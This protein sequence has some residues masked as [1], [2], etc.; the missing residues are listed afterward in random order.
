MMQH[1]AKR[2]PIF[3][4]LLFGLAFVLFRFTG[5]RPGS[6]AYHLKHLGKL[7][8]STAWKFGPA[9]SVRSTS[10]E[11]L[12]ANR[13]DY[14][15]PKIWLWFALGRPTITS[16]IVDLRK[17]QKALIE[18]GYFERREFVLKQGVLNPGFWS[19]FYTTV[20]NAP[21][22]EWRWMIDLEESRPDTI[23]VTTLKADLPIFEKIII[24]L[25]K[26]ADE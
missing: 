12:P 14:L 20:S 18:M 11:P 10:G 6:A 17:H 5:P 8:Q 9:E 4:L 19:E 16:Q 24:S 25:D 15:R 21:L 1:Y 22:R 7:R 23:P 2:L 26:P 3:I 13:L